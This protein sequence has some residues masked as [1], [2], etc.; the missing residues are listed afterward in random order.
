VAGTTKVYEIDTAPAPEPVRRPRPGTRSKSAPQKARREP[1]YRPGLRVLLTY[2]TG[3]V[4]VACWSQ[5]RRRVGSAGVALAAVAAGLLLVTRF[6]SIGRWI[7]A[8]PHGVALWIVIVPALIIA[9][10]SAWARS[11]D[12]AS[13]I[14][15]CRSSLGPSWLRR[16]VTILVLGT[17]VPG[18]GLRVAGYARRAA[19]ALWIAGPLAAAAVVLANGS[20]LWSARRALPNPGISGNGLESVFVIA[21]A[22][23]VVAAL[24]W[25]VQALDGMRRVSTD[26]S[27]AV[28]NATSVFLILALV[29]GGVTFQPRSFAHDLHDTATVIRNEGFQLI[30]LKLCEAAARLDP[31]VPAY[32]ADAATLN[33][34]LNMPE[35][36]QSKRAVLVDRLQTYIELVNTDEAVKSALPSDF[37]DNVGWPAHRPT[38][39]DRAVVEMAMSLPGKIGRLW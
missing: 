23:F 5:G 24:L 36:A 39:L 11:I 35:A 19:F 4:A 30:P 13:R 6:S 22:V 20:W 31:T 14:H 8:T 21:T 16:P 29:C 1:S 26:D 27:R 2:L 32:L 38:A 25:V 12:Q 10:V 17:L 15:A 7:V 28:S 9:I 18:L 37:N 34:A 3:P 33:D